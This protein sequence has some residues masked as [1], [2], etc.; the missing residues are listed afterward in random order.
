VGPEPDGKIDD[1][2]RTYLG[3]TIP[4]FYYGLNLNFDY[5]NWD[6][7]FNFRGVGDVQKINDIR[8]AREAMGAGGA[9]FLSTVLDRWTPQNPSTTMPRAIAND[10]SGNNRMSDRWVEDAG[11]FRLQNMQLGYTLSPDLLN[12]VGINSTRL[13]LS[14]SNLFVITPYS[15]LDPENDTTPVIFSAGININF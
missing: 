13:Y 15:G 9:N 14:G 5:N 11:F 7:S 6:L 8:Q 3:K 12:K 2:D 4:G 1:F 10:P